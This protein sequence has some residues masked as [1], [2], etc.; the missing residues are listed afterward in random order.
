MSTLFIA[1]HRIWELKL[2]NQLFVERLGH[3]MVLVALLGPRAKGPQ[4]LTEA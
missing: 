3:K 1:V 2:T 4:S